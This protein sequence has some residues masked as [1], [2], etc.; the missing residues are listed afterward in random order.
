[1]STPDSQTVTAAGS[2]AEQAEDDALEKCYALLRRRAREHR[3]QLTAVSH[4]EAG[5]AR[6]PARPAGSHD[7]A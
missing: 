6:L 4:D 7:P 2:L 5:P 1:M 3:R